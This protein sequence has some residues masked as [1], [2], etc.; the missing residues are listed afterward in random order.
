MC[1][2][3][4]PV[5]GLHVDLAATPG[6]GGLPAGAYEVTIRADGQTFV[7]HPQ[8][9]F[10]GGSDCA[11]CEPEVVVDGRTLFADVDLSTSGYVNVGYWE[12]GGPSTIELEIRQGS[13]VYAARTFTPAYGAEEVNGRGCG[14]T[15]QAH[16]TVTLAP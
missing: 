4:L 11:D 14:V 1:T 7:A 3:I 8:V 16:E 15:H 10:A 12:D 9:L 13:T 6:S 2:L 5:P